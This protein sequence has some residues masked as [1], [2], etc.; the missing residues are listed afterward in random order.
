MACG[1]V[2]G[3]ELFTL[4]DGLLGGGIRCRN[5]STGAEGDIGA[6]SEEQSDGNERNTGERI[7][8]SGLNFYLRT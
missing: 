8:T 2:G 1:A 4:V 6:S 3:E 7:A 5:G